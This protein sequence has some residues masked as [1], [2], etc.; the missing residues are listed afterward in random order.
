[1]MACAKG[2]GLVTVGQPVAADATGPIRLTLISGTVKS[3]GMAQVQASP[4]NPNEKVAAESFSTF[5]PI[6]QALGRNNWIGVPAEH[7]KTDN[8][9]PQKGNKS[10]E[11]FL[12]FCGVG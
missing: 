3:V 9:V 12:A 1:M 6:M 5:D 7:D 11:K 2:S 10:I 8:F 4:A